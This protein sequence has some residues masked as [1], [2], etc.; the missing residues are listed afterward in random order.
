MTEDDWM[1]GRDNR[2]AALH[3]D[4]VEDK[5]GTKKS[6]YCLSVYRNRIM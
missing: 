3:I 6:N 2:A 5:F 1:Y 4:D